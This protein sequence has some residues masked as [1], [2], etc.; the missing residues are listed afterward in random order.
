VIIRR[1]ESSD[2]DSCAEL[3]AEVFREEPWNEPWTQENATERLVHI[4]ESKGFLGFLMESENNT[5][6]FVL[7][8]IEPFA[9]GGAF[10]LREMCVKKEIQGKGIGK[11]LIAYL[12]SELST[13]KAVRSYLITTRN[14][15]SA[16]F[17]SAN[18]YKYEE[19]EG[20]YGI[21][22]NS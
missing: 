5:V 19:R 3:F 17:Y 14:G 16:A 18:G 12:H 8:N 22:I 2:I 11:R 20:V 15:L 21:T 7:G 6:G 1:I 9:G 10:Y 13:Q 4:Y